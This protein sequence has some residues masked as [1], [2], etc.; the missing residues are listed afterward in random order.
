MNEALTEIPAAALDRAI[1]GSNLRGNTL[2][3]ELAVGPV[4]MSFLRHFG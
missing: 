1:Q 2:R 3:D 4:L